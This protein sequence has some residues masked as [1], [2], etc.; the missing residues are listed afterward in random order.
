MKLSLKSEL[1]TNSQ[2]THIEGGGD[3]VDL[4]ERCCDY[5]ISYQSNVTCNHTDSGQWMQFSHGGEGKGT[6]V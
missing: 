5:E 1:E 3:A 6:L 2:N 4:V